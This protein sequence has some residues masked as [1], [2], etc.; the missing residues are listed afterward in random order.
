MY[1]HYCFRHGNKAEVWQKLIDD[2]KLPYMA[3]VR[4]LRNMV[5]AGISSDHVTAVCKYVSN[6]RAVAGS[7]MFP[8]RFYTA[9]DALNDL[10]EMSKKEVQPPRSSTKAEKQ[11]ARAG[12]GRGRGVGRN[13]RGG[14]NGGRGGR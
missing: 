7:R 5:L 6:P 12:A 11:A 14:G 8:F 13:K 3:T 2:K 1:V 9:F 10:E 4:N